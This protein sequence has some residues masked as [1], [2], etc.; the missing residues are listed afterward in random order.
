MSAVIKVK[1]KQGNVYPLYSLRGEQGERGPKGDP[2]PAGATGPK[3]DTGPA[4]PAGK[5]GP[6]GDTGPA[7]PKGDP[8]PAGA[9]GPKGDT[10]P[11]GPAGTSPTISVSGTTITVT[12]TSGAHD[13]TIDTYT[14]AEID[15]LIASVAGSGGGVGMALS[16]SVEVVQ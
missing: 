12:D 8:G 5:A 11:A 3:G 9:T 16:S 7:G 10:G 4:G 1:D 15:G 6:K 14:K 13:Y 2:G